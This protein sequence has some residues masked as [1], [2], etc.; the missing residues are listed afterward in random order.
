MNELMQFHCAEFGNLRTVEENG[1]TLFCAID[2]ARALGYAKPANAI[3]VH[4][5]DVTLK[6]GND[7]L[8]RLQ[9][10]SFIPEGD[11]YRLIVSSKL[12]KA[13]QFEKWVFDDV[14]PCIRQTGVYA[15]LDNLS[16]ELR[17]L[18]NLETQQKHNAQAIAHTNERLDNVQDVLLMGAA[19]WRKE[20]AK[21]ISKIAKVLYLGN[22]EALYNDLYSELEKRAK[23][24]LERRLE[25]KRKRMEEKGATIT[26][27]NNLSKQDVIAED[28]RLTEIYIAVVK[29]MAIKA[30]VTV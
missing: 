28:A 26:Q 9:Q 27:V 19:N 4:C 1:K 29:E 3:S 15:N 14:L 12:P 11:V 7:N 8:G 10:M 16:P 23:C 18:I 5:K 13:Q 20:C 17:L 22:F 25:N 6:Q 21:L 24:N 30:G 2:V